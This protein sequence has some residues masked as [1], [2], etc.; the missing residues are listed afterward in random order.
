MIPL[1]DHMPHCETNLETNYKY[2]FYVSGTVLKMRENH[3]MIRCALPCIYVITRYY[4]T[5]AIVLYNV[6]VTYSKTLVK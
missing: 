1:K 4:T 6:S 5:I 2:I 3:I